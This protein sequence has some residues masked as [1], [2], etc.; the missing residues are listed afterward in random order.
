MPPK[1]TYSKAPREYPPSELH[2][3]RRKL[4]IEIYHRRRIPGECP[5]CPICGRGISI[6]EGGD[7]HEVFFTRG[8]VQGVSDEENHNAIFDACNVVLVH[9]G[10]CHLKAQHTPEGSYKC[11]HQIVLHEGKADVLRYIDLM[12]GFLRN[13]QAADFE[14]EYVTR[15]AN[16]LERGTIPEPRW[17][18]S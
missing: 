7:M 2:E 4:K 12:R 6:E 14:K 11:A 18:F 9:N 13:K 1:L 17:N 10:E 5:L 15:I 8:D 3:L 16:N